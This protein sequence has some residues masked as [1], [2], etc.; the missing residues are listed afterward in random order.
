MVRSSSKLNRVQSIY[1]VSWERGGA[2]HGDF[3][4]VSFLVWFWSKLID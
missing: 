4:L 3:G 2:F 1:R